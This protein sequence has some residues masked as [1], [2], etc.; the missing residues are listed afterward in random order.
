MRN[1]YLSN[2][3]VFL[4]IRILPLSLS[5]YAHYPLSYSARRIIPLRLFGY[6]TFPTTCVAQVVILCVAYYFYIRRSFFSLL[7]AVELFCR[8][9]I[10]IQNLSLGVRQHFVAKNNITI[11][12]IECSSL[13]KPLIIWLA[14]KRWSGQDSVTQVCNQYYSQTTTYIIKMFC[15]FN[16]DFT[17]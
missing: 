10:D 3:K 13:D 5:L 15:L 12:L 9:I 8:L 2:P 17:L 7:L 16:V 14:Q 4:G 1:S 11:I 6:L